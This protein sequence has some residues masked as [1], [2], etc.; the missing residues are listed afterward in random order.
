MQLLVQA[1]LDGELSVAEAAELGEHLSGCAACRTAQD[2]LAALSTRIRADATKHAAPAALRLAL[3]RQAAA[4]ATPAWRTR[5]AALGAGAT[6]ALAASVALFLAPRA[7]NLADA[8]VASHIRALQPGHLTDV[9]SSDQHTV[10]PW[11]DGRLDYAPPVRDFATAGFPL[12]GGRLDYLGGRAVAALVYRR[13]RHL[14]DLYVWPGDGQAA[15]A[16]TVAGYNVTG[17]S[18]AGMRWLAVSDLNAAELRAFAALWRHAS[19]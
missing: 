18:D 12:V 4:P 2:E 9:L 6:L 3:E 15:A 16:G 1:D 19:L 11:F 5:R 7:S 8:A 14:I 17:W 13:E 10:K